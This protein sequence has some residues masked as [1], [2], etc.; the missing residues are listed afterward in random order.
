MRSKN[1]QNE[2]TG[3]TLLSRHM[4]VIAKE[5]ELLSNKK[6]IKIYLDDNEITKFICRYVIEDS[7]YYSGGIFDVQFKLN[8]DYP[9]S[10]PVVKF[11]TRI[12]HPNINEDGVI[13]FSLISKD[14]KPIFSLSRIVYGL[15]SLIELPNYTDP[16]N[17]EAGICLEC[18]EDEF[19]EKAQ[20][21]IKL[22]CP[23]SVDDVVSFEWNN[24][25][26]K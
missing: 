12:W 25:Y 26:K 2:T 24:S 3:M 17:K 11:L 4:D 15:R 14:Y 5:I 22:Y 9:I 19:I 1:A 21:Y 10:P 18:N 8:S 20:R 23:K 6:N 16:I 7:K 13:C